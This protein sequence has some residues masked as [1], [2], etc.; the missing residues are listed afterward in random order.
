MSARPLPA[1]DQLDR[2]AT[3][4]NASA[5]L[6]FY[7][8]TLDFALPG[9]V[10]ATM[11]VKP[12]HRGGLGTEAVN[13]AI[14]ASLFDLAIGCT[15]ALVDPTRR[16]AT[17]QLSMNFE[18]A[19]LGDTIVAEG[20]IDR[21]GGSTLFSSAV[22]KNERGEVCARCQ[23]VVKLSRDAWAQGDSPAIN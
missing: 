8:V 21:A 2:Y 7:G 19:L 3:G 23:G 5:T 14:I 17:V 10:R 4:F 15:A 9:R 13:G 16:S 20:W 18:R 6:R 11:P 22:L 1:P 12:E